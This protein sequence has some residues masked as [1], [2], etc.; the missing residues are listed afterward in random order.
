MLCWCSVFSF[1]IYIVCLWACALL[2][3][4][5]C[6]RVVRLFA[7][8]ICVVGFGRLCVLFACVGAFACCLC[9]LR[10]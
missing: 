9:L 3:V 1:C 6:L 10:V 5:L 8:L 2:V 7:F 4:S